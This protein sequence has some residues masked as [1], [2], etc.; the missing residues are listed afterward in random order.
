MLFR[1]ITNNSVTPNIL[2]NDVTNASGK[3]TVLDT[4]PSVNG[5]QI[6]VTEPGYSTDSTASTTVSNPH[7]SKPNATIVAQQV[8]AISF[9]IDQLSTFTVNSETSTCT[10]VPGYHFN[11]QGSKLVGTNPNVY[12]YSQNQ[13]T[14]GSAS[15]TLNNMEWDSYAIS[16][17][18][19]SY[20]LVGENP[21]SP[22]SLAPNG[23]QAVQLIV[24]PKNPRT[25]LVT[26]R[27][28]ATSLPISGATVALSGTPLSSPITYVTGQGTMTQTDWSGGPG[29][30]TS[31]VASQ[32]FS[33]DGNID[34]TTVPGDM[35]LKKIFGAYV[36]S[37]TLTSSSFDT[38]SPSN[39]Q[40]ISWLPGSQPPATGATSVEFQV[41]SN[42]DGGTWNF[43]G[44][45]GTAS[46]YYTTANQNINSIVN[47]NRYFRYKIIENTAST[48]FTP[49]VSDVSFTFTS[50]CTPP[51]QVVFGG[52]STTSSGPYTLTISKAGYATT[53]VTS[54]SLS[55]SWQ[56]Q[57]ISLVSN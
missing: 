33:T 46:T 55:A 19:S 17:T 11:L 49:D 22:V 50:S 45:D 40:T 18:D 26:V 42:N 15:L 1:S 10:P 39:F 41:A 7:P 8:T 56:S 6:S 54:L 12:K 32:Y 43:T 23:A 47:G 36:A 9:N 13:M 44:P 5:Y 35:K 52:L 27:D 16:G 24:Q 38:G 14:N 21:L 51:G 34:T 57:D 48:T 30:A 29:Q 28:S 4:P 2:I 37:G 53:T 25:L 3:L 31:T 20:D